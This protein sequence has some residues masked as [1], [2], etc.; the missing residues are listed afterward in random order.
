MLSWPFKRKEEETSMDMMD[1]FKQREAHFKEDTNIILD[2]LGSIID[3]A[4]EFV[5]VKRDDVTVHRV[6]LIET[7]EIGFIILISL[8]IP[9]KPGEIP[10]NIDPKQLTGELR[11]LVSI[12]VPMKMANATKDEAVAYLKDSKERQEK[13]LP[14]TKE[15]EI[16]Q[17]MIEKK[18]YKEIMH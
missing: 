9:I 14:A 13:G 15:I 4:C 2:A 12:G 3:G 1:L 11:H 5:E 7:E 17:A 18:K 8:N 16:A 6:M 10:P